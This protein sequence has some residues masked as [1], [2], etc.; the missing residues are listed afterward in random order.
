MTV[1]TYQAWNTASETI[2]GNIAAD[3]PREARE[4]LRS[5]GLMVES[6]V[7]QK[8]KSPSKWNLPERPGRYASQVASAVRDLSTLL[9]TGIGL[10]EALQ[11]ITSQFKGRFH[12]SLLMLQQKVASGV[13]LSEAMQ[14]EPG[15]YDDLT[16]QMVKVGENAGT[17]DVVL[18]RLADFR[19][20]Y[21]LF[22]DKITTAL[23]YPAIIVLIALGVSVFLM[24]VVLP[25][26]LENL[27]EAGK[28]LPLPTKIL[29]WM[30]DLA[31]S[32]GFSI[33]VGIILLVIGFF[34]FIKTP[35]GQRIWHQFLFSIPILGPLAKKQEIARTAIII[36]T[37]MKNG[38]VFLEAVE[39]AARASKNVLL[40][41]ALQ[42]IQT[43]VTSGQDIGESLEKTGV[44]PALV[45]QIFTIGQQT[46]QLEEMLDRLASGYERQVSSATERLTSAIEPILIVCLA[47]FVGFI[48]FATILPILEAG[49]VL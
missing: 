20:R 22:K 9:S 16:V 47:T 33:S 35:R 1:F 44:F 38:I 11:T 46:G 48:L 12:T 6:I 8:V 13:S 21:L 3:S 10:V 31:I 24:T 49:N 45:V 34:T 14:E 2:S 26:L 19:E 30:S 39:I 28:E 7:E 36:S 23:M 40:K 32:H 25:M 5:Q 4:K 27:I 15:I 18:D 43:S 41:D 29:K 37:L 17:L 42:A